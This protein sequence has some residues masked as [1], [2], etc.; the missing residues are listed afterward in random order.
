M[1]NKNSKKANTR[2]S[3]KLNLRHGSFNLS[4]WFL[5][6]FAFFSLISKNYLFA[7][8][9]SLVFLTLLI[10]QFIYK[11]KQ[12]INIRDYVKK[13]NDQLDIA[14]KDS[15]VNFPFPMVVTHLD[16]VISWYNH[17]FGNIF[18]EISLFERNIIDL[19]DAL[20]WGEILRMKHGI[21]VVAQYNDRFYKVMGNIIKPKPNSDDEYLVLL[22]WLDQ[23][24]L[25]DLKQRYSDKKTDIGILMIDNYDDVMQSIEDEAKPHLISHIDKAISEWSASIGGILRKL[26]RDRYLLLFEH[27]SLKDMVNRKFDILDIVRDI[28]EGNK[29][30]ATISIGIGTGSNTLIQ[31]DHNARSA[32]DMALGRGGDQAVIKDEQQFSFYGG[33]TKEHEKSTRVKARVVAGALKELILGSDEV[34]IMGHQNP[35]PDSIGAAIGIA[36]AVKSKN[37]PVYIVCGKINDTVQKIINNTKRVQGYDGVFISPEEADEKVYKNSLIIIVDT[38]KPSLIE[39]ESAL[40]R[41]SQVVVIDHHRRSTEFIE[42]CSLVYHEPYASST[43]EMVTEILQYFDVKFQLMREEAEA[44]FAGIFMDTKGFTFKTGVRTFDAASYLRKQGVDTVVV[45]Q[46]FQLDLDYYLIRTNI[47]KEAEIFYERIAI[48]ICKEPIKDI[49]VIAAQAS[50]EMLNL[51]GI[52]S[53]FVLSVVGDI[54]SINGRSLGKINVQ[55]ILEKLG[56]GGH[57]TVAGAQLKEVDINKAKEKLLTAIDEY[58]KDMEK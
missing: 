17:S 38:H 21:S 26:E 15:L 13:I 14:S 33:K 11:K 20:D 43:C 55:L 19:V 56:G 51:S 34:I 52:E 36:R 5:L 57:M 58:F 30:E 40:N 29:T 6:V 45:K 28:N 46:M 18:K 1:A 2:I 44:L 32:I 23:T 50:D 7:L 31:N 22:Y 47:I 24:D 48:A 42:G 8:F 53:S 35:D 9:Q 25:M 37:K 12:N 54:I 41:S 39:V 4:V 16:G 49:E 3:S 10:L 27:K